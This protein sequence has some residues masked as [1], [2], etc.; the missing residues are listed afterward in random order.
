MKCTYFQP[1]EARKC[2]RVMVRVMV[3]LRVMVMVMVRVRVRARVARLAEIRIAAGP[4]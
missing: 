3:R 2:P 4:R 1:C